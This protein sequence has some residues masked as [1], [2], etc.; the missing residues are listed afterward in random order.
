MAEFEKS[1]YFCKHFHKKDRVRWCGEEKKN[2]CIGDCCD[3][4]EWCSMVKSW[5]P[6]N[7]RK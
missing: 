2:S 3:N 1:C 4:F 7:K 5:K 6:K